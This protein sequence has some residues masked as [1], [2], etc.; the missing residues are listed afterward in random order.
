M[1]GHDR[2]QFWTYQFAGVDQMNGRSLYKLD[3]DNYTLGDPT[4][5][6]TA[7]GKTKLPDAAEYVT[8]DGKNYVY[9]TSYALRD[10]SGSAIPDLFGSFTT[11]ASWKNWTLSAIL[12]YS[13]GGKV[14][15]YNYQTYMSAT[16][17]PSSL[18]KDLLNS[19]NGVP[20][21]ITESSPNR[22]NPNGIPEVNF[23]NSADNNAT[24][25]RF[26]QDA[27]YLLLKNINLSYVLPGQWSSKLD[28]SRVRLNFT[29][30]NLFTLTTLK[31]MNPQ[32]AWSGLQ[33]NYLPT[34][35]IISFGINVQF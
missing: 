34:A 8:I 1:E 26:L 20:E 10:W 24:S 25:T 4:A 5:E 32:Q 33:Y 27:S 3:V 12:T 30:E 31:G 18:H 11:S 21:G 22:I 6:E 2:Y 29:A 14:M 35:R 19:W 28:L 9:K 13:L 16:A 15:E 17:S 23:A 7:A